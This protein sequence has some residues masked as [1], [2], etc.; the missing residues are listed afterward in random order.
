M[1]KVILE[2]VPVA[3][4]RPRFTKRG[5]AYTP[6]KTRSYE[7]ALQLVAKAA[8]VGKEPLEGPLKAVFLICVPIPKSYTKKKKMDA[9]LNDIRPIK[10]PDTDNFIKVID[11]LNGVCFHDDSQIV[12]IIASKFYSNN[13]RLEIQLEELK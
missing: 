7:A 12:D 13:P 1:I 11:A 3:K 8:M 5:F 9:L 4:G 6:A 10:K 2:G